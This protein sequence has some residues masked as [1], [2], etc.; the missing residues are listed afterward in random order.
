VRRGPSA[1]GRR[2]SRRDAH[3][4]RGG[5]GHAVDLAVP[6]GLQLKSDRDKLVK[7]LK[8]AYSAEAK[9]RRALWGHSRTSAAL[10]ADRV[11]S[12]AVH[13]AMATG[14][15]ARSKYLALCADWRNT[16]QAMASSGDAKQQEKAEAH[17]K[18]MQ[19]A[20]KEANDAVAAA[21]KA[22]ERVYA[23]ELPALL[24][25]GG[26]GPWGRWTRSDSDD[27][28]RCHRCGVVRP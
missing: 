25:V 19:A 4:A 15:Q 20:E 26:A 21:N 2:A 23:Q 12:T 13:A 7:S 9:A 10:R 3:R 17:K 27:A 24:Q 5:C 8:E 11:R 1:G 14:P 16:Y 28:E 22:Q 18:K 6:C